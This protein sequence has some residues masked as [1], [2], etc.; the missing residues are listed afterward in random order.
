MLTC[1]QVEGAGR[2]CLRVG[3]S[4]SYSATAHLAIVRFGSIAAVSCRSSAMEGPLSM[5]VKRHV[6]PIN[7]VR[8]DP[9]I[10]SRL[11]FRGAPTHLPRGFP[12]SDWTS[13][14]IGALLLCIARR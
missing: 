1:G 10:R 14:L 9:L 12:E 6:V 3:D 13:A 7:L 2:V 11:L 8:E 4:P 5:H